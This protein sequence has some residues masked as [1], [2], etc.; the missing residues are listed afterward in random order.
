MQTFIRSGLLALAALTSSL[1]AQVTLVDFADTPGPYL[2]FEGSWTTNPD[3]RVEPGFLHL[4]NASTDWESAASITFASALDL[5]DSNRLSLLLR[6]L[7]S[8][9]GATLTLSLF[10]AENDSISAIFGVDDPAGA[11]FGQLV[12]S[13]SELTPGA[14]DFG[15]VYGLKISGESYDA[16]GYFN[17]D[18]ASITAFRQES[19]QVT[20]VPEPSTYALTGALCLLGFSAYRR[21]TRRN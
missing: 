14:F 18:L 2:W 6:P 10:D 20:P 5:G 11:V 12:A 7:G 17:L 13:C 1:S 9:S 8:S 16:P 4:G 21:R 3:V 15:A 19:P